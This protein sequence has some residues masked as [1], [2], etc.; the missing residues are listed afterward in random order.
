G[1]SRL[2][3]NDWRTRL[4]WLSSAEASGTILVAFAILVMTLSLI[5][6]LAR[7]GILCLLF[8]L[9]VIVVLQWKNLGASRGVALGYLVLATV[10]AFVWAG[11]DEIANR[12]RA[13]YVFDLAGRI[14]IWSDTVRVIEAFPLTGTGLNTYPTAM[15]F[16]QTTMREF[17]IPAAHNDYLQ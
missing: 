4:I 2:R 9:V 16:F 5:L 12:F 11:S 7:S 3:V 13:S 8:A 17:R 14:P 15:L 6:A 10:I 1:P